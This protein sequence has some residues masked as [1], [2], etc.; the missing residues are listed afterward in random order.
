MSG[1]IAIVITMRPSDSSRRVQL[2][3]SQSQQSGSVLHIA[4]S[5]RKSELQKLT[6]MLSSLGLQTSND[7]SLI[8][9]VHAYQRFDP[10]TKIY[11][12]NCVDKFP[13]YEE[14]L[15]YVC[16]GK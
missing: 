14:F 9:H 1:N 4:I 7:T 13:L 10:H 6:S 11:V 2:S 16:H 8:D 3:S 15:D 12:F 5:T